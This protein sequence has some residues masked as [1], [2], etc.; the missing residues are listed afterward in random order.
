MDKFSSQV[1]CYLDR[2]RHGDRDTAFF[3]LLEIE[4]DALPELTAACRAE[5]D[6]EIRAFLVEVIWQHGCPS[7]IP[8][9]GEALQDPDPRVWK[10]AIDGLV[11][12][13]SQAAL[14]ALQSARG[15]DFQ[16]QRDTDEFCAWLKEA[17]EQI[18]QAER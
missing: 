4:D 13:A 2:L 1:A 16:Q 10:E 11:T 3:G 12:M 8:F 17:I 14:K 7:V 9:L 18:E 15:R 6:G 5:P